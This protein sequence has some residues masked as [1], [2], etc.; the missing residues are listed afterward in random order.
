MLLTIS[1]W[2]RVKREDQQKIFDGIND[3]VSLEAFS[4]DDFNA[5]M[6]DAKKKRENTIKDVDS[7]DQQ[8]LEEYKL[9]EN[10]EFHI[11]ALFQQKLE[12]TAQGTPFLQ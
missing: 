12:T 8:L 6:D 9:S 10:A 7:L 4:I 3:I 2:W 11:G 5:A 1:Q